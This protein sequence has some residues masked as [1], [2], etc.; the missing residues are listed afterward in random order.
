MDGGAVNCAGPRFS[1]VGTIGQP[2]AGT[3]AG[4]TRSVQGGFWNNSLLFD[5]VMGIL[6]LEAF[7]G[8]SRLVTFTATDAN[9]LKLGT[10]SVSLDFAGGPTASY[11][12]PAVPVDAVGLSAKTAWHLRQKQPV[13]WS[14]GPAIAN[15]QL[16]AGDT[17]GSNK[18]DLGDYFKLASVWYASGNPAATESDLDGNGRVDLDD[19]FL[20]SNN[21]LLQGDLE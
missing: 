5:R 10:W 16:R 8:S 4:A 2:D 17:D 7:T 18:V 1:A 11:S 13:S 6:T 12:L 15:F 3:M 19:Y 21:W 14:A 9:C 20:L